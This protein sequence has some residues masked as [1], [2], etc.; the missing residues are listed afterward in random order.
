MPVIGITAQKR[1]PCYYNNMNERPKS[2]L[3]SEQAADVIMYYH[4]AAQQEA[5]GRGRSY[6]VPLGDAALQAV[7]WRHSILPNSDA[8]LTWDEM[9]AGLSYIER[10]PEPPTPTYYFDIP[11][12]IDAHDPPARILELET[13]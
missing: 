6:T 7:Q 9:R 1:L 5:E 12:L 3:T 4:E 13:E 11:K 2:T 8:L 10:P